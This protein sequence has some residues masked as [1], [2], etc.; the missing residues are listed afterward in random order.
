MNPKTIFIS[1]FFLFASAL[2]LQAQETY[3]YSTV[4]YF[5]DGG[6]FYLSVSTGDNYIETKVKS[7]FTSKGFFNDLTPL[8]EKVNELSKD[9]WEVYSTS[10]TGNLN[11]EPMTYH[12][13]RKKP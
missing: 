12:L 10:S 11:M 6:T 8:L 3:E 7:K 1:V 4:T 2:C 9:G 5:H 13:R